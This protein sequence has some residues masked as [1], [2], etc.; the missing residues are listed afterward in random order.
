[1]AGQTGYASSTRKGETGDIELREEK[2]DVQK[3]PV[4]TGEVHVRKVVETEHKTVEVPV[5]K[6][7]V[8][9]ERRPASGTPTS[10]SDIREGE[11]IQIPVKEEQV[12]VEKH[13]VVTERVSVGK[14]EV[15]DTEHVSG[16]VRK[17]DIQV[18]RKATWM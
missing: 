6:E 2:L 15:Q 11:E 3:H 13:P 17:E 8:V 1:M 4:K 9:I 10:S 12:H 5:R 18:T 14:R 16:T 7:E